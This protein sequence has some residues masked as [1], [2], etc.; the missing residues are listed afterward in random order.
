M[1]YHFCAHGKVVIGEIGKKPKLN[2]SCP[3]CVRDNYI[4]N[5]LATEE[6]LKQPYLKEQLKALDK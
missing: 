1:K 5:P 4:S 3:L 2:H 6:E